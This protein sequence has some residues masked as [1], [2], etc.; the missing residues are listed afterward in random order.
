MEEIQENSGLLV[1]E[2]GT[3]YKEYEVEGRTVRVFISDD[4]ARLDY[5]EFEEYRFRRQV[6]KFLD[7]QRGKGIRFWP[8][9]VPTKYGNLGNTYVKTKAEQ[10][11][12]DIINKQKEEENGK[13]D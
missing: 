2:S 13:Q 7:K 12:Q 5:E 8:S 3:K 9:V 1:H 6:N 11:K 10:I 4:L